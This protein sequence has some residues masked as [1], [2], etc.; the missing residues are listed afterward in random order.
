MPTVAPTAAPVDRAAPTVAIVSPTSGSSVAGA[1]TLEASASDDVAVTG[2]G[3]G[4]ARRDSAP[5]PSLGR[6]PDAPAEHRDAC[7]GDL[8]PDREGGRRRRQHH[9]ERTDPADGRSR[10]DSR[11]RR[12]PPPRRRRPPRSGLR[13]RR[14]RPPRPRP[15]RP[16]R[17]RPRPRPR[18]RPRRPRPP[19]PLPPSCRP[20]RPWTPTLAPTPEPS[21]APA[22]RST[23]RHRPS[24]SSRRARLVGDRHRHPRRHRPGRHGDRRYRLLG[25]DHQDR[26]RDPRRGRHLLPRRQHQGLPAGTS[27]GDRGGRGHTRAARPRAHPSCWRWV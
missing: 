5:P 6:H 26:R 4:S 27:L 14:R 15:R 13:R 11:H 23:P 8:R 25:R 22:P 24:P 16:P 12:R 1:V 19:R 7:Q 20:S 9:H 10:C 2:V 21:G 18:P 17:R 3:F